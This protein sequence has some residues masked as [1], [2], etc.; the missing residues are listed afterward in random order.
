DPDPAREPVNEKTGDERLPRE[1][2]RHEGEQGPHVNAPEPY[3]RGP[4]NPIL[5]GKCGCR[6]R[7]A[8]ENLCSRDR[9]EPGPSPWWDGDR[10]R[11]PFRPPVRLQVPGNEP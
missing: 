10:G 7:H 4:G 11:N 5:D 1:E 3:Q 6:G 9:G 8:G 2:G